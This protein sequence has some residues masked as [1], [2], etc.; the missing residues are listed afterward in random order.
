V[1]DNPFLHD[2]TPEQYA[3]LAPLFDRLESPARKAIFMQGR[4]ATYM[5]VLSVGRVTLRYKPYDGPKITLTQL[6]SGD[7]F[8][9]SA[10]VGNQTYTS[11]AVGITPVELLRVRGDRLRGLCIQYPTAGKSI[12]EKLARA[13]SPRWIH[14]Q[15]QVQRMLKEQVFS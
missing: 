1:I 9:W 13:V 8:G 3:L 6:R 5:Y 10:V 14:A 11:E 2:L 7:V 15:E 4:P 12:L